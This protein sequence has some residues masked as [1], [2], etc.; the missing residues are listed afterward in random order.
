MKGKIVVLFISFFGGVLTVLSILFLLIKLRIVRKRDDFDGER[1][2]LIG[3]YPM[4]WFI[5]GINWL[6]TKLL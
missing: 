4:L 2:M 1:I 6:I 5:A 3:L